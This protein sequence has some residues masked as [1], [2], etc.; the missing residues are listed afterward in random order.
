MAGWKIVPTTCT[1]N[2][3]PKK[4][5]PVPSIRFCRCPNIYLVYNFVHTTVLPTH[6]QGLAIPRKASSFSTPPP[7]THTRAAWRSL[8][9]NPIS[10]F[11]TG[12]YYRNPSTVGTEMLDQVD[13]SRR[14]QGSAFIP[15]SLCGAPLPYPDMTAH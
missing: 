12:R 6:K 8:S 2:L 5:K 15:G 10:T 14:F 11:S 3:Q 7:H 9:P 13:W 1:K 4:V